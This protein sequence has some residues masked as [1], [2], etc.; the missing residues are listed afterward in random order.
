MITW[1]VRIEC[2]RCGRSETHEATNGPRGLPI[3]ESQNWATV[4]VEAIAPLG[5]PRPEGSMYDVCRDC[6]TS[7]ERA[8]LTA[9]PFD[10]DD[11]PF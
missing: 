1:L 4:H 3:A 5:W 9:R 10:D 8:D 6:L 2:G 7:N 11:I